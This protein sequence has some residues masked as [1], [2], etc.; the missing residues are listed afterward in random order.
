MRLA[1]AECRDSFAFYLHFI[2]FCAHP[3]SKKKVLSDRKRRS[4]H[5]LATICDRV[6]GKGGE[7]PLVMSWGYPCPFWGE[8]GQDQGVPT[9]TNKQTNWKHNLPVELCTRMVKNDLVLV[10]YINFTIQRNVNTQVVSKC[11]I[12]LLFLHGLHS[13]GAKYLL[14]WLKILKFSTFLE[15]VQFLVLV[16][17]DTI[18]NLHIYIFWKTWW[19]NSKIPSYGW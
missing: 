13:N 4:V 18:N 1:P 6:L 7:A 12:F 15:N 16:N 8:P 14:F 3:L 19:N 10:R 17:N 9:P 5:G 2:W 11:S